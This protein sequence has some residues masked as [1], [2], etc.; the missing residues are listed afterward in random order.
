MQVNIKYN[1]EGDIHTLKTEDGAFPGIT[2][3]NTG[4]PE[5]KKSGTAKQ[6]LGC[7]AVFCY[8]S[9]LVGSMEARNMPF[10]H[11]AATASLEVGKN[12]LGLGRI[13]KIIIDANV[14]IPSDSEDTFARVEK[15]MRKGC[16]VTASLHEGIEMEYKLNHTCKG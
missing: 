9:A 1:R 16:L 10:S 6:L 3:D 12:D 7:A 15:V 5:E 13:T 8:M 4:L 14:T 2:V 11:V